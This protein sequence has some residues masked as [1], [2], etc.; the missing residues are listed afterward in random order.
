[1]TV[2]NP[3]TRAILTLYVGLLAEHGRY[4]KWSLNT[5]FLKPACHLPKDTAPYITKLY[6]LTYNV[7]ASQTS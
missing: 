1:M 6:T 5:V 7:D 2:G 3:D 4:G